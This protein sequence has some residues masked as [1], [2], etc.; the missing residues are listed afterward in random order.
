MASGICGRVTVAWGRTFRVIIIL[1]E[2]CEV[3]IALDV[4]DLNTPEIENIFPSKESER[5][6]IE[7]EPCN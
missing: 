1:S 5:K 6:R 2:D 3:G 4:V 7:E